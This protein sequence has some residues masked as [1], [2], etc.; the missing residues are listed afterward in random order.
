M[1]QNDKAAEVIRRLSPLFPDPKSALVHESAWELLVATILSAQTTDKLVNTVTPSL[2]AT[3]P[4]VESFATAT[5][6]QVDAHIR[7]VNFHNTKAKNIQAAAKKIVSE[8]NGNVPQTLEELITLP[9]VGRKTAN[10]VLGDAFGI[11]VGVVVDTHVRR[12]ANKLGLTTSQDPEKIEQDLM[13]AVPPK[14]WTAFS[15]LLILTGRQYCPAR[16]HDCTNC[17]LHDLYV[18]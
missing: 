1:T 7:K 12:L 15:H 8:F 14:H 18:A 11:S 13:E 5:A 4:T 16:K 2:F 10:V 6:E 9:G 17:P 3:F